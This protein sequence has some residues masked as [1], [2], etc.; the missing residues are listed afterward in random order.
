LKHIE[1]IEA[2]QNRSSSALASTIEYVQ[3]LR[4]GE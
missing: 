1:H 2:I 4:E 3:A